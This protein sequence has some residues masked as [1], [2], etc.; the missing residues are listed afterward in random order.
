MSDPLP[1]LTKRVA[2]RIAAHRRTLG[3]TQ[4]DLAGRLGIALKNLQRLESG[5]Q[6]LTLNTIARVAAALDI[7][8]DLVFVD[9]PLS[10]ALPTHLPLVQHEG[11]PPQPIPVLHLDAAAGYVRAGRLVDIVGW[12]LLP[13]DEDDLFVAQVT[14]RSMEPLIPDGSWCLFRGG[15]FDLGQG[16]LLLMEHRDRDELTSYVVKRVVRHGDRVQLESVNRAFAPVVLDGMAADAWRVI[17]EWR[18][19]VAAPPRR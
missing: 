16:R 1:E 2:R 12:T 4:E 17:G 8:V 5:R 18:A 19:V 7:D 13:E 11:R 3:L 6:N 9:P 14:G 10:R 15:A